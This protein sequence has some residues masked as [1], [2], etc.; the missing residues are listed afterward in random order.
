MQRFKNNDN[1]LDINTEELVNFIEEKTKYKFK[2]PQ[3]LVT[4]MTHKTKAK[5]K[6][7]S[8]WDDYNLLEFL[9]DSV[10]KFFNCKRIIKM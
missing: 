2:I 5:Y 1:P 3:I 10:I 9:G 4:A 7:G 8:L 6:N